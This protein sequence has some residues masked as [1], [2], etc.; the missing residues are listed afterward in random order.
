MV[1]KM[2]L[3]GGKDE[4]G[5]HREKRR[6]ERG[7]VSHRMKMST[8]LPASA[9]SMILAFFSARGDKPWRAPFCSTSV[10]A[11]EGETDAR[12]RRSLPVHANGLHCFATGRS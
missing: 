3:E 1:R 5:Q 8:V 4:V 12:R 2:D 9:P 7:R 10:D 6:D 11:D